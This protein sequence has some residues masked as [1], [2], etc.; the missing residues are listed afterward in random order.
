MS[1]LGTGMAELG[2]GGT[3]S[4]GAT[5]LLVLSFWTLL[6]HSQLLWPSQLGL[7]SPGW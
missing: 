4:A 1:G 7:L 5:V 3:D 6:L 2:G